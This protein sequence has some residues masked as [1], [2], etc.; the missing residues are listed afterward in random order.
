MKN[1]SSFDSFL[2]NTKELG[3]YN[4]NKVDVKK[5]TNGST[6]R[7]YKSAQIKVLGNTY[8][9]LESLFEDG[10]LEY[11]TILKSSNNPFKTL[12]TEFKTWDEAIQHYKSKEMKTALLMAEQTF[13]NTNVS[14][15]LITESSKFAIKKY[16]DVEF[17]KDYIISNIY[18][19]ENQNNIDVSISK[20]DKVRLYLDKN[21]VSETKFYIKAIRPLL[22]KSTNENASIQIGALWNGSF[23]LDKEF[24][25]ESKNLPFKIIQ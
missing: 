5:S 18:V 17:L 14:E 22:D 2:E 23:L 1:I 3:E 7:I 25:F 9:I 13:K 24:F 16:Y 12:G 20:G 4:I 11:V 10:S 19:G 8:T 21:K 15:S 6:T